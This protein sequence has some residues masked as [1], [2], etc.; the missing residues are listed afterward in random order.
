MLKNK[1]KKVKETAKKYH[2]DYLAIAAGGIAIGAVMHKLH[3]DHLANAD[4]EC[5]IGVEPYPI[6]G[7]ACIRLNVYNCLKNGSKVLY[8]RLIFNKGDYDVFNGICLE[9]LEEALQKKAENE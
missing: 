6:D 7:E 1:I 2:L 3:M 9:C 8:D 5:A 4:G